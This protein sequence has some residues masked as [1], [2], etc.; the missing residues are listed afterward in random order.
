MAWLVGVVHAIG[1]R[2]RSILGQLMVYSVVYGIVRSSE[3]IVQ[4]VFIEPRWWVC[5]SAVEWLLWI[6]DAFIGLCVDVGGCVYSKGIEE[7]ED[8]AEGDAAGC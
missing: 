1:L 2:Q 4:Y 3:W 6:H 5:E 7:E 8:G